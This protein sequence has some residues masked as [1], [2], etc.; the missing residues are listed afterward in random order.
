VELGNL[1]GLWD[2]SLSNNNLSG[3]IP[4]ELDSLQNLKLLN[5]HSN[6][7]SG[8]IPAELGNLKNL[9]RLFLENNDLSGEIPAEL[10]KLQN[11]KWL[12][13]DRNELSG[14]IPAELGDLTEVYG[15]RFQENNFESYGTGAFSTQTNL[16][17]IELEAPILNL[18]DNDLSTEDIDNV[19]S[20]LVESLDLEDR[21]PAEVDLTGN[22]EP[23]AEGWEDKQTLEAEG[24]EVSVDGEPPEECELTIDSTWGG[25]VAEPGEGWFEYEEGTVV[26]LEAETDDGYLFDKWTGDTGPI[27][28]QYSPDTTIEMGGDHE[29][30]AEFT[31]E[32]PETY[33]LT[34]DS[35]WG[36]QVAEPGEGWF[37]YEEGTVVDL[38]AETD[39]GYVFDK[40]TG[41][42]DPIDD[43]Y[44]PETSIVMS[45]DYDITADFTEEP[46]EMFEL[47]ANIDGEGSV[48]I[49]PDKDEYEEGTEVTLTADPDEGWE[50]VEWTGD[51]SGTAS[52][53]TVTM[54]EDKEIT[55]VFE[56]EEEVPGFTSTL[57]LLAAIIAVAIYKKKEH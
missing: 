57:L 37:E 17:D 35:T 33:E 10:G 32:P 45:S 42:T 50:F 3:E 18:S 52:T 56:E 16:G 27:D 39:D 36:G 40:W 12:T 19:L 11:L 34:I 41:D 22:S 23:S 28:D 14:E 6:D 15:M 47:T 49:D 9:E 5:L 21:V 13:V 25:Q 20:D 48:E 7:L 51:E 1:H 24:W 29:I 43:P 30:T 46:L 54:D 2:L 38:E 44:L 4:T 31:E 53:I 8:E 55:A 26:D